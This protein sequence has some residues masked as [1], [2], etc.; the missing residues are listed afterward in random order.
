MPEEKGEK[1][2]ARATCSSASCGLKQRGRHRWGRT[3]RASRLASK[4]PSRKRE[5]ERNSARA[6][7]KKGLGSPSGGVRDW[8]PRKVGAKRGEPKS[9]G[10]RFRDLSSRDGILL[11]GKGTKM[12]GRLRIP[13]FGDSI[14][15]ENRG[16]TNR[17]MPVRG[18]LSQSAT[19]VR[20]QAQGGSRKQEMCKRAVGKNYQGKWYDEMKKKI[21]RVDSAEELADHRLG[22]GGHGRRPG[23]KTEISKKV[24]ADRQ[25]WACT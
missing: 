19:T 6:H 3:G 1:K 7:K 21:R 2:R 25:R 23:G 20:G 4:Y 12:K 15:E 5:R 14:N 17:T 13:K 9:A 8:G 18:A 10:Y 11:I 16:R 22:R 24:S